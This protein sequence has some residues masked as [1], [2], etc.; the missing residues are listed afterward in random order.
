M[1]VVEERGVAA[2]ALGAE[3]LF[4]VELAVVAAELGVSFVGYFT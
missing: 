3:Q 2:E 4:G 1:V